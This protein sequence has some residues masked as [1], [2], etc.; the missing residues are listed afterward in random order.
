MSFEWTDIFTLLV[1]IVYFYFLASTI[2]VLILENRNPIRSLAWV[3]VLMFL[4]VLGLIIYAMLGQ[5]VRQ[6]KKIR[7][8]S[9]RSGSNSTKVKPDLSPLAH[10]TLSDNATGLIRLLYNGDEALIYE[11]SKIDILATPQETF[12][13]IFSD[14]ESAKDHI[15]IE[16]YIINNDEVG[17]RLVDLLT[18]KVKEGVEVRLI[19]DYW[20]C[21]GLPNKFIKRM[22]KGGIKFYAFFPPRFPFVLSR[23][24]YRNHRKI[25]VVD[26]KVGYTGGINMAS[27]YLYGNN[28]GMWRDTMVRFEGAATLGL[29]EA[30][31]DDWYF[32]DRTILED[33]HYFP[34]QKSFSK[35]IV[36][37][38]DSGPDTNFQSILHGMYH[39]ISTAQDYV[40]IHTPYFM[41]PEVI[42]VAIETAALR[43]VDV[44]MIIPIKSDASMAREGNCSYFER[45]LDAGV[46]IFNYQKGFLHSKAWVVDDLICSVGTSNIDFRSYEQ[47]FEISA[48]IYDAETALKIKS[49]FTNDLNDCVE[50]Y[51]E[52]W[53]K[54][55]K[56]QR[57]R[58]S[59]SRLFSPIL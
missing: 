18:Q 24:N 2:I 50:I 19:Y 37:V 57:F 4:P 44:Q 53:K 20:G 1:L 38:V 45:M 21:F 9:I 6:K 29:Q 51:K 31:S 52:E 27:R 47:N 42:L 16:F 49:L 34:P 55:P 54:R 3:M 33:V 5:K 11:N 30:F 58:E 32:E 10:H 46:R 12:D 43:G 48:F 23:L 36:Q 59:L 25:I 56:M 15:H 40:Y 28:L 26:G 22:K 39:A 14:L 8:L 17:N 35:N 41:P 13:A 7:K